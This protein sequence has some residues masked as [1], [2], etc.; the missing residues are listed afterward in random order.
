MRLHGDNLLN[1]GNCCGPVIVNGFLSGGAV[2]FRPVQLQTGVTATDERG[3][4]KLSMK[5]AD[6]VEAAAQ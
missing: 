5:A 2:R 4:L 1:A 3:R 6:P